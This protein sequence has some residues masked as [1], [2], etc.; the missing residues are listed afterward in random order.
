MDRE[1]ELKALGAKIHNE[2]KTLPMTDEWH[3][4]TSEIERQWMI[5]GWMEAYNEWHAAHGM[6]RVVSNPESTEIIDELKKLSNRLE[7]A[8]AEGDN[9]I[10]AKCSLVLDSPVKCYDFSGSRRFAACRAWNL[11]ETEKIDWREAI[12]RAWDEVKSKCVWD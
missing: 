12:K 10:S 8:L 6:K 7:V 3:A 9:P 1:I 4:L 11:M 5:D 2:G